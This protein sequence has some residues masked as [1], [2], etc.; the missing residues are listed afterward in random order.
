MDDHQELFQDLQEIAAH[1]Q[2]V[3][4]CLKIKY[5]KLEVIKKDKHDSMDCLGGMLATWLRGTD[6]ASPTALVRALR[7]AGMVALASKVAIKH[8]K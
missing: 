4:L 5:D 8:G 7:T 6:H 2:T 3:G 1:W